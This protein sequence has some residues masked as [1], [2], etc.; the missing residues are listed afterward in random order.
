MDTCKY[1]METKI[2]NK[3]AQISV[4][5]FLLVWSIDLIFSWAS[6]PSLGQSRKNKIRHSPNLVQ[7][8]K[9][10]QKFDIHKQ[11]QNAP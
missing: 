11:K 5:L 10:M 9:E 2:I 7:P 3:N 4:N 8:T 6:K 1:N